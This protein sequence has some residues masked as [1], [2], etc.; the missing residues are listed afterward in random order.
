MMR[1]EP[2]KRRSIW[3][4]MIDR[5]GIWQQEAL[6]QKLAKQKS[7][8][9]RLTISKIILFVLS[10][11]VH[12]STLFFTC[13]GLYLL[14]N[15]FH[16]FWGAI[17]SIFFLLLAWIFRP[18]FP[19]PDQEPLTRTQYP[20]LFR[21]IDRVAKE[22]GVKSPDLVTYDFDYNASF[23]RYGFR[24]KSWLN[25][26]MALWMQLNPQARIGLI[27]HE[28]AHDANKDFARKFWVAHAI[29]TLTEWYCLIVP[30]L[31]LKKTHFILNLIFGFWTMLGFIFFYLLSRPIYFAIWIFTIL[32]MADSR[33]AEYLADE[34]ASRVVGIQ[35]VIDLHRHMRPQYDLKD[36]SPL[37]FSH[38]SAEYRI[39]FLKERPSQY[40]VVHVTEAEMRQIDQELTKIYQKTQYE[41]E[42]PIMIEHEYWM[43]YIR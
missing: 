36:I 37:L 9:P 11:I 43:D 16:L 42:K 24:Q 2:I 7:L 20:A 17:G 26:G 21:F 1:Y 38:P 4:G 19:I 28:L 39:R 41:L 31:N 40:G 12:I 32:A 30:N 5:L 18:R 33:R 23:S 29:Q 35:A 8:A 3:S 27:A 25:I 10:G 13:L 14:F 22:I 34:Y 15:S 6:F